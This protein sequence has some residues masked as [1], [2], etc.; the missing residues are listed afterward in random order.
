MSTTNAT[1]KQPRLLGFVPTCDLY[2]EYLDH[3]RVPSLDD[4]KQ[5]GGAVEFCGRATTVK[6]FEDNSRLK[7]LVSRPKPPPP[8]GGGGHGN[9]QQR[10]VLV[11]D[12]GGSRRCAVLGD[13]LALEA[14]KRGWIAGIVVYGCVRDSVELGKIANL[15]V[16]ALGTTPRKST[17]RG[18][19]QVNVPVRIGSDDVQ[20]NPND[21][22][23]VDR[24][25]I[26]ILDPND[27]ER[28]R[29]Q[30]GKK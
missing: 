1:A 26:L 21:L 10:H 18:E 16:V 17:R 4:W 5:Y 24:D 25:G 9:E 14:S 12:A 27:W 3:A 22:V 20:V 15:G 2:D 13:M 7:E 8:Q 29:E 30:D 19:G 28:E 23:F 11:V 6:C